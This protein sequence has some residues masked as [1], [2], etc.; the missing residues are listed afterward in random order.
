MYRGWRPPPLQNSNS[1]HLEAL[2]RRQGR[3]IVA[4]PPHRAFLGTHNHSAGPIDRDLGGS[5]TS[6]GPMDRDFHVLG[7][8]LVFLGASWELLWLLYAPLSTH[9]GSQ[10]AVNSPNQLPRRPPGEANGPMK[11]PNP[12][13]K[14][15]WTCFPKNLTPKPMKTN[16]Q[17]SKESKK[18]GSE[19]PPGCAKQFNNNHNPATEPWGRR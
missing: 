11:P 14:R 8:F 10:G 5:E 19:G 13:R 2:K 1:E 16:A 18:Q 15:I 3:W 17:E 4:W 6:T 12:I 9:L 7:L